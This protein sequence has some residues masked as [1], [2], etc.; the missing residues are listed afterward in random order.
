MRPL[1]YTTGMVRV[2][3]T[4]TLTQPQIDNNYN[5][6]HIKGIH[7]VMLKYSHVLR[8]DLVSI[9]EQYTPSKAWIYRDRST[10]LLVS[11]HLVISNWYGCYSACLTVCVG[12]C[13]GCQSPSS[14]IPVW[15]VST[16]FF[17]WCSSVPCKYSLGRPVVSQCTLC[18]PVA[19]QWHS[20]VHW[21]SQC[22]LAEGKGD[23]YLQMDQ[24]A[25]SMRIRYE[26]KAFI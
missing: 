22:T 14:G 1:M 16:K 9:A 12:D 23:L 20:R 13:V 15:A 3:W 10:C 25:W 26:H 2:V 17:Q 19:F 11:R 21:T 6:V 24:Q 5:G 7:R 18:Q 4:L 8:A